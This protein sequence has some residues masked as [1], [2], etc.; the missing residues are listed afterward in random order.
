MA[1]STII[2]NE[3]K[4]LSL[5]MTD[6]QADALREVAN[7]GSG[8]AVTALSEM[9][10][11]PFNMSVPNV[12]LQQLVG[13]HGH[14]GS[15]ESVAAAVYMPVDGDAPGH[16][17]FVFQLQSACNLVDMLLC[18]EPGTTSELG[19]LECSALMEVGNILVGSF[20]GALSEMTGLCFPLAP[21]G[22][23]IDMTAAIVESIA[24]ASPLLGNHALTITTRLDDAERPVEGIFAFIPEPAALPVIFTALGIGD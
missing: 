23:A 14:L 15:D 7:V 19:E 2:E 5:L 20:L 17:A 22:I 16:A 9:T 4:E 13:I 3:Y 6:I 8:H 11:Q 24:A 1:S 18:Q 21:P 10:G 12:G